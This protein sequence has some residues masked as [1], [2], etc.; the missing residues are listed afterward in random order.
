MSKDNQEQAS[1]FRLKNP[2][3]GLVI[4][5]KMI[6]DSEGNWVPSHPDVIESLMKAP[7]LPTKRNSGKK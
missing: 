5:P 1:I 4:Y 7:S 6:K 2:K 3:N